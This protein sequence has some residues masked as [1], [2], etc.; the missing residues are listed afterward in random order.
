MKNSISAVLCACLVASLATWTGAARAVTVTYNFTATVST[1]WEYD[2]SSG[3][4]QNVLSS[5]LAGTAVAMNDVLSGSFTYNTDWALSAY[6]PTPAPTS[7]SWVMYAAPT[8]VAA[9]SY[10][11]NGASLYDASGFAAVQVQNDAVQ[12]YS[13][14]RDNFYL[15]NVGSNLAVYYQSA[16]I[17]LQD[18]TH[19]VFQSDAIPTNLSLASF[20]YAMVIGEWLRQSDGD[21]LHMGATLTSLTPSVSPVPEAGTASLLGLGLT[22]VALV[23]RRRRLATS[24]VATRA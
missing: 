8:S 18:G 21:Q 10:S 1:L 5:G 6:Q 20:S 12:P 7:G 15:G 17:S 16:G 3:S 11:V 4:I 2:K 23:A 9:I 13:A 24:G 19:T 22:A 14:S